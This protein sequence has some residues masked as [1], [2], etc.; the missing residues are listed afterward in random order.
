[1]YIYIRGKKFY[2][3]NGFCLFVFSLKFGRC[4]CTR[5]LVY[6]REEGKTAAAV[7]VHSRRRRRR[8]IIIITYYCDVDCVLYK[9]L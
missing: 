9:I 8:R 2:T 7:V 4:T 3:T 6:C 5:I 1:M